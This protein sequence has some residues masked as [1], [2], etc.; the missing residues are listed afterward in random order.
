[1]MSFASLRLSPEL[2]MLPKLKTALSASKSLFVSVTEVAGALRAN[3]L[4]EMDDPSAVTRE[5]TTSSLP[6]L[7]IVERATLMLLLPSRGVM[8]SLRVTVSPMARS[9]MAPLRCAVPVLESEVATM[10]MGDKM[11]VF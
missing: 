11:G 3:R 9:V 4:P 8:F 2:T 10:V 5:L 1:M 6:L 7:R